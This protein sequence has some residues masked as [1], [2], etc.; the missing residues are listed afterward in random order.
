[1][2]ALRWRSAADS[3][4]LAARPAATGALGEARHEVEAALRDLARCA[5][6]VPPTVAVEIM[7]RVRAELRTDRGPRRSGA[8]VGRRRRRSSR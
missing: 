4:P 7:R 3:R 2:T 5:E 1:M 6:P 8:A